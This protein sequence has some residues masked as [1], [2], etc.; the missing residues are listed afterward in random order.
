MKIHINPKTTPLIFAVMLLV[1]SGQ[2]IG[3]AHNS[4]GPHWHDDSTTRSIQENK[5]TGTNVG[6]AVTA[7]NFTAGAF[8]NRYI[9]DGTDAASFSIETSTGQ[10]KTKAPLNRAT[11]SQYSVTVKVSDGEGGTDTITVTIKVLTPD[12]PEPLM[13]VKQNG[14][15][16][17]DQTVKPGTFQLVMEFDQP[18]TGFERSELGVDDFETGATITGWQKSTDDKDYTAT[19]RT[20]NTGSVTF[21]VPANVA[22]AADDGQG[23]VENKLLVLVTD[24]GEVNVAP[25]SGKEI[26]PPDETLLLPNYP[27]PFNPETWIPYQLA[28]DSNVQLLIYNVR[29]TIVRRLALRHQSAG[30]YTNRSRAAHWD[31][32][33]T[34]GERVAAGIYFYQLQADKVTP[35][36]KMVI[37]K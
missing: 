35:L 3:Y 25:A 7:H 21:R 12:P 16:E 32:R 18:V 10:L 26:R 14:V 20:Q 1:F 33:N 27:N 11:K 8:S 17:N 2:G 22:Q 31:G 15:E 30:F 9:L 13:Y 34:S 6:A 24:S 23:N 19:V 36:R 28:K 4:D 29:G 37:L 5:A